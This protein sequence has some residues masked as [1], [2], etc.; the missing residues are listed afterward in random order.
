MIVLV[1]VT[2]SAGVL[3]GMLQSLNA[4]VIVYAAFRIANRYGHRK[5]N[6]AGITAEQGDGAG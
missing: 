4:L 5:T 6:A 2:I 1:L 3:F